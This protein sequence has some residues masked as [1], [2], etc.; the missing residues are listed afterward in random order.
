MTIKQSKKNGRKQVTGRYE[1]RE[2]LEQAV[3]DRYENTGQNQVQI[4][5]ATK[6]SEGTVANI[7]KT[8]PTRGEL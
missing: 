3:W 4:A 7:L 2:E 8:K 6:V 5:R 1:T